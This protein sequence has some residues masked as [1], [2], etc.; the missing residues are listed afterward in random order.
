MGLD[1]ATTVA[2][3]RFGIT[4]AEQAM[5]MRAARQAG[6]MTDEEILE[7]VRRMRVVPADELIAKGAAAGKP[8]KAEPVE[9]DEPEDEED[10]GA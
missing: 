4:M 8:A 6:D 2:L 7:R 9:P 5:S 3:V 10:D 1:A